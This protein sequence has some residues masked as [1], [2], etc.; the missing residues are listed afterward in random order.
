MTRVRIT[1]GE[2]G[3]RFI[4]TL[5]TLRPTSD[6]VRKAL[7][8]ILGET[9]QDANFLDLFAGCGAVG[10]EAISRGARQ[11]TFIDNDRAHTQLIKEN[12]TSLGAE[13]QTIVRQMDVKNFLDANQTSYD[14]VFADPWYKEPLDLTDWKID[15]LLSESGMII[16][17]HD[18][19]T[20]PLPGPL[21]RQLNRKRYGDTTLTFYT[22]A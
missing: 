5:P 19:K 8:D 14:I 1:S 10:L 15:P 3:G 9:V 13:H 6:L 20:E 22:R 18:N 16:V 7:F 21:L 17:E 2:Y 12:C 11:A 4:K